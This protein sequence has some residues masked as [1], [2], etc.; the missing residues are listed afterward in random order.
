M[1]GASD[2]MGT[3]TGMSSPPT[4]TPELAAARARFEAA[5]RALAAHRERDVELGLR[6]EEA[7][8]A[9]RRERA[10]H[11]AAGEALWDER[12]AAK[13]ELFALLG[14]GP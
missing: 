12:Y 5:L 1:F 2:G 6:L 11:Q 9:A 3:G 10:R 7:L 14:L 13:D 8:E 4:E